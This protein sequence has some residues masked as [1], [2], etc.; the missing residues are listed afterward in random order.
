[1][2]DIFNLTFTQIFAFFI[3]ML[4]GYFLRKT[5]IIGD[6]ADGLISKLLTYVI[7]PALCFGSFSKNFKVEFIK[8]EYTLIICSLCV[9]CAS[10]AVAFIIARF[11]SKDKKIR[12]IYVY[13]FCVANFG[14][15]GYALV[16]NMLGEEMLFRMLVYC[17]PLNVFVSSVGFV[18][19]TSN[20]Q[21]FSFKKFINPV[22]ISTGIGAVVGILNIPVPAVISNSAEL[23]SS[24]MGPMA[25]LLTG[26]VIAQYP[27]NRIFL[28]G[29][30]TIAS[31]L[32]LVVLP[33]AIMFALKPF[34]LPS[35]YILLTLSAFA[36]PLGLN[37]II[38]PAA[39]GGDTMTGASMA[40][41]SNLMAIITVPIM[42]GIFL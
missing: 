10:I 6:G 23:L 8:S 25:M 3:I 37:S 26:I 9:L 33:T 2:Q 18:L 20:G 22:F 14:Y 1:M 5:K 42:F 21:K 15:M 19:L 41:I 28:N 36:M 30:V 27:L 29:K 4:I 17:L 16:E 34:G 31:I 13:S 11:F 38:Y 40:L 12:D 32:R 24:C 35:E 7:S 39:C